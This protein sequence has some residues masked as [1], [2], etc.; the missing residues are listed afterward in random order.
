MHDV[1]CQKCE[2]KTSTKNTLDRACKSKFCRAIIGIFWA[3]LV[4]LL[5]FQTNSRCWSFSYVVYVTFE[6]TQIIITLYH[7][8]MFRNLKNNSSTKLILLDLLPTTHH[9]MKC[10]N[11]SST[12]HKSWTWIFPR[13]FYRQYNFLNQ[14]VETTTIPVTANIEHYD[15]QH[16]KA[17]QLQKSQTNLAASIKYD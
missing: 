12:E 16:S 14:E 2:R 8:V 13:N 1:I 11:F 6:C 9:D 4:I 7:R 3:I 5:W 15:Q 10:H 17:I